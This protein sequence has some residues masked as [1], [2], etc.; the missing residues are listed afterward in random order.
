MA[1]EELVLCSCQPERFGVSQ[2]LCVAI[3]G[4]VINLSR[5]LF[6]VSIVCAHSTFRGW[7]LGGHE[8]L[9]FGSLPYT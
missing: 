4:S 5:I 8:F 3:Y 1:W 2:L 7:G 9:K 6:A